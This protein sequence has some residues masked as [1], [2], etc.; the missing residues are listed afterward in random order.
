MA[1]PK[2]NH[3]KRVL[4]AIGVTILLLVRALP[5]ASQDVVGQAVTITLSNGSKISGTV[6][7]SGRTA[8]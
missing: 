4:A 2:E 5:A 7:S 6:T 3:L 8:R 1:F